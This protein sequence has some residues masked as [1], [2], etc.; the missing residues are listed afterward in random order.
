M[1]HRS[2]H[3]FVSR[4]RYG[5]DT[6]GLTGLSVNVFVQLSIIDFLPPTGALNWVQTCSRLPHL[7][8]LFSSSPHKKWVFFWWTISNC[9]VDN[10]QSS[11]LVG[12]ADSVSYWVDTLASP[13]NLWSISLTGLF[14]CTRDER[15]NNHSVRRG[16]FT[17]FQ[18]CNLKKIQGG[19]LKTCCIILSHKHIW[20]LSSHLLHMND[21]NTKFNT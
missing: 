10:V 15:N 19:F 18:I 20:F 21:M 17:P 9:L 16:G 2:K 6:L 3:N 14:P 11:S 1:W 12:R 7:P 13:D 8:S 5:A 4:Y